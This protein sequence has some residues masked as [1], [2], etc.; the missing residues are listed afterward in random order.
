MDA[1]SAAA[2]AF[3]NDVP[4]WRGGAYPTDKEL[5][6]AALGGCLMLW[7]RGAVFYGDA[8]DITPAALYA[9]DQTAT[10]RVIYLY[11]EFDHAHYLPSKE[12]PLDALRIVIDAQRRAATKAHKRRKH[13]GEYWAPFILNGQN[14]TYGFDPDMLTICCMLLGNSKIMLH[15][16]FDETNIMPIK[17]TSP[18]G[19]IY[20]LPIRT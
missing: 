6:H 4:Q 15:M 16:P 11:N 9:T 13:G 10:Q 18:L 1:R 3:M 12:F 8:P 14:I 17:L 2:A 20:V 5:G 19:K 7:N